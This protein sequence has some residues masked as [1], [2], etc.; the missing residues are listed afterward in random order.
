LKKKQPSPPI[1]DK[2]LQGKKKLSGE[3]HFVDLDK[4]TCGNANN[5]AFFVCS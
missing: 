5:Y 2:D 4:I 3:S 1:D